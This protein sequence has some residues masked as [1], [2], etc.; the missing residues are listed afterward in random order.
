MGRLEVTLL[1]SHIGYWR[2]WA[3]E[4]HTIT[5]AHGCVGEDLSEEG[6]ALVV[7]SLSGSLRAGEADVAWF[8]WLEVRSPLLSKIRSMSGFLFSDYFR[9]ST[10]HYRRTLNVSEMSFV[11]SLSQQ[12]RRNY[13]RRAKRL[14]ADFPDAV[15]IDRFDRV[16]EI[17]RLMQDAE[18][19]MSKSYQRGLGVG[20]VNSEMMHQRLELEAKK[21]WLRGYILYVQNAPCAFWI[22]SMYHGTFYS[23]FMAFDP[24]YGKYGP[25]L[26]LVIS[27]LDQLTIP[28]GGQVATFL[29]FGG[30]EAEWK[31]TLSDQSTLETSVRIFAPNIRGMG[32][33]TFRTVPAAVDLLIK[34]ILKKLNVMTRV[35]EVTEGS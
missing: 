23:D 18:V 27:A 32:L 19:V 35:K 10:V 24:D 26:Y 25:G 7:S 31:A 9:S 3:A 8:P 6:A 17:A 4:P 34:A 2:I 12:W 15:R 13:K 20:F 5:L 11:D 33:N 21:D 28:C 1:V 16:E 29:D 22:G 14:L 30:G